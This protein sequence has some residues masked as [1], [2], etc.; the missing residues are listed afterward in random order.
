MQILAGVSNLEALD[1]HNISPLFLAAQYGKQECLEILVNAGEGFFS[2][3]YT[4]PDNEY[5]D[6][7]LVCTFVLGAN[8]NT[9]AADLATPLLIA[10]QEGHQS[11]VE[12]LLDHGA[13]PNVAC[14]RDWPQLAIHA[15]AEFGHTGYLS[16][17]NVSLFF[18]PTVSCLVFLS[19]VET[20]VF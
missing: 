5:F 1:D 16:C 12:L 13:D 9:Q 17:L 19:L 4:S 14:S 3:P 10:S 7:D 6:F 18:L 2:L 8:V 11:C 20:P 15:A